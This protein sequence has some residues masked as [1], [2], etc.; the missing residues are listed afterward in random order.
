MAL[1]RSL[2]KLDLFPIKDSYVPFFRHNQSA[3]DR[4]PRTVDR[5]C[6]RVRELSLDRLYEKITEPKETNWQIGSMFRRW[7]ESGALGVIPCDEQTFLGSDRNAILRGSDDRLKK[8]AEEH[9]GFRRADNKGIDFIGRFNNVYVIGEAKFL[10]D[11]GGHQNGQFL[12]AMTTLRTPVPDNVIT[13]AVLD[14]VLYIPGNK[15]MFTAITTQDVNVMSA[16]LLRDFLY[17]LHE[18]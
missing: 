4:N 11:E 2:L 16:L 1:F 15:K 5:I 13:I 10:T 14:G 8:F 18:K 7:L 9:L 6:A 17:S 3:I 12:D